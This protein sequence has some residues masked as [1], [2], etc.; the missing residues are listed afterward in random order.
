[1]MFTREELDILE[2]VLNEEIL[3]IL[4]SGYG[5]K[6]SSVITMRGILKKLDL[7][8]YYRFE[9]WDEE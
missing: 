8:E 4:R 6:E 5:T 2:G 9:E 7:K 3:S 1:M